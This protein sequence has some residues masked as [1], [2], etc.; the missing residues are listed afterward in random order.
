MPCSFPR[1]LRPLSF[2]LAQY[3]L[4]APPLVYVPLAWTNYYFGIGLLLMIFTAATWHGSKLHLSP[5]RAA[6]RA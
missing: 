2:L 5:P 1:P 4:Y 3:V 6:K